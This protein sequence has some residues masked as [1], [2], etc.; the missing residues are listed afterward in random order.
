[1]VLLE[2]TCSVHGSTTRTH[3]W[4]RV[5]HS[6]DANV[7]AQSARWQQRA[8][9]FL[10]LVVVG[11]CARD[12]HRSAS[13][14][15]LGEGLGTSGAVRF[16]FQRQR[17]QRRSRV[18]RRRTVMTGGATMFQGCHGKSSTYPH[19]HGDSGC[20]VLHNRHRLSSLSL[21]SPQTWPSRPHVPPH[22]E[23]VFGD[24]SSHTAPI[25][26]VTICSHLLSFEGGWSRLARSIC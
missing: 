7:L 1:M 6:V 18:R 10:P 12:L 5:V 14:G 11:H 13:W 19:T 22:V 3:G 9:L 21:F 2:G 20:L 25:A 23:R 4:R 15:N 16:V 17:N 24:G 8:C 26:K